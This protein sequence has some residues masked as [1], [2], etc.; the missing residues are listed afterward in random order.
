MTTEH[1]DTAG[2]DREVPLPGPTI[3]VVDDDA[4]VRKIVSRGLAKLGPAEVMEVEDGL[5]ATTYLNKQVR[6]LRAAA[7]AGTRS[8]RVSYARYT[9]GAVN[10]IEVVDSETV[11]LQAELASIRG[12]TEQRLAL[13]R[14]MKAIGGGWED[15]PL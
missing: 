14:L 10:F 9:A 5:A 8:A 13:V 6:A 11:R 4:M 7:E 2:A 12:S 3:L 15:E 1:S